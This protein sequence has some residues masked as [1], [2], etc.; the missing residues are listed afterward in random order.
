MTRSLLNYLRYHAFWTLDRIKG[1]N[2]RHDFLDIQKTLGENS[3]DSLQKR[4]E[5]PLRELLDKAVTHSEFYSDLKNYSTLEDFPIT[6]KNI[7]KTNF[8]RTLIKNASKERIHQM[9]TSG[10]TGIPFMVYQTQRK[11]ERN[12]A[13]TIYFASQAGYTIGEKLL[14]VRL[15]NKNLK[16]KKL[17]AFLQNIVQINIDALKNEGYIKNLLLKL[18]KD[19][20]PKAWLGY[21]SGLEKICDYL[22][23]TNSKPLQC[24]VRSIIGMSESLGDH[25]RSKM[26]Y[27]F[28]TPMVSRY[29]NFENGIIA[30][31]PIDGDYFIINWASYVVEILDFNE[32]KP[33][34]HGQL[35][36]IVIT[37]LYNHATPMIRYDTGDVGALITVP[38]CPFPVLKSVEG[39]K[40]DILMDTKGKMTSPYKYMSLLPSFPELNQV[41]FVQNEK[42]R[43]T[44]KLNVD[45][46]F[47]REMEL[48]RSFKEII[49]DDAMVTVEHVNEIPL[50]N[51]KKRKI[52]RNLLLENPKDNRKEKSLTH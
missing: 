43:Y 10:S 18:Q 14:Y 33:A 49:G 28:N 15:W 13:D 44:I 6:N 38:S 52:T 24:N 46:T 23:K 2:I 22:D 16:K 42:N 48:V 35:G 7:I 25:V 30:Q 12:T 51:S 29:S 37:D 31:Q 34:K 17:P 39:R 36:R 21:P 50:L 4:T 26:W 32:D 8:D 40:A 45:E 47:T 1:R 5:K 41:Q 11:K 3:F 19:P 27:Y 9:F 20:S